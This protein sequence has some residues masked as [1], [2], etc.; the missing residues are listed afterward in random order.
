MAVDWLVLIEVFGLV[1]I[2]GVLMFVFWVVFR[3][4]FV[5]YIFNSVVDFFGVF[6][7]V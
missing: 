1:V 2:V 7:V 6:I 4:C 5:Y 3:L